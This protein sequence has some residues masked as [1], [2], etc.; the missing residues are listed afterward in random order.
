MDYRQPEPRVKSK[1][2]TA[3]LDAYK[4]GEFPDLPAEVGRALADVGPVGDVA[5]L[6]S[7]I[8]SAVRTIAR[9]REELRR[10]GRASVSDDFW[11]ARSLGYF[12]S[13]FW[14]RGRVLDVATYAQATEEQ[15]ARV[16]QELSAHFSNHP[17]RRLKQDVDIGDLEQILSLPVWERRY[18]LYSAWI[19]TLLLKALDG[20]TI[21]LEHD[22]GR[23]SFSFRET[24]MAHVVSSSPPLAIYSERRVALAHPVG[25]GRSGGAQPD[26]SFWTEDGRCPLAV[27]CKHYKRSS[28]RNFAM[29]SMTTAQRSQTLVSCSQTMGLSVRPLLRRLKRAGAPAAGPSAV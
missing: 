25:H 1:A 19:L 29:P 21:T 13:D 8:Y 20:H 28:T 9:N 22:D 3:W 27:E 15:R 2:L 23:I 18:E 6:L 17:R 12:E 10:K 24:L 26:Y 16:V 14:V 4:N 5:A 7:E 11:G